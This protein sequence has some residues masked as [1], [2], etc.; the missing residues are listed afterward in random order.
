[1]DPVGLREMVEQIGLNG[2]VHPSVGITRN[3]GELHMSDLL[4]NEVP[5]VSIPEWAFI[6]D[7][8]SPCVGEDSILEG[9]EGHAFFTV[10][11]VVTLSREG[12]MA[13][14]YSLIR[15]VHD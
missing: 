13:L 9:E 6:E 3:Y 2:A 14:E 15:T 12:D 8:P 11:F 10:G 4:A 5:R 1:M 7:L